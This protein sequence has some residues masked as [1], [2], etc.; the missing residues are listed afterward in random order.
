MTHRSSSRFNQLTRTA[1]KLLFKQG[2]ISLI[3]RL[4]LWLRGERRYFR[5]DNLA[6]H[7][8]QQA[9]LLYRELPPS[10]EQETFHGLTTLRGW[11]LARAGLERIEVYVDG[12]LAGQAKYGEVRPDIAATHPY[13]A[14]AD[15]AG[16]SFKWDTTSVSDGQHQ[17][18]FQAISSTGK[19]QTLTQEVIVDNSHPQKTEY[20][21]WIETYE[22]HDI[23]EA[24][25]KAKQLTVTP[26]F[27][28]IMP[29][30]N[31]DDSLLQQAIGSI[32]AQSYSNWEL[33]M[34]DDGSTTDQTWPRL[35]QAQ[36]VDDRI[37]VSRLET[38][39]GISAASNLALSQATGDFV[40]LMDQDDEL[41]P[42]ALY[43][44]AKW[45]NKFP[46]ADLLYSDEDK[47]DLDDRRYDPFFKPD[48][49]PDLFLSMNYLNH[50]TVIRTD[51]IRATGGFREGLEGSQDYD[52]YLRLTERTEQIYHIP[53]VL[54]H[55]RATPS[56]AAAD[57]RAKNFAQTAAQ[58]AL[59]EHLQRQQLQA[60]VQPVHAPGRWR[61]QYSVAAPP[62][63]AIIIPCYTNLK[64]LR[65]LT[66]HLIVKTTYRPIEFIIIDNSDGDEVAKVYQSI[67]QKHPETKYLNWQNHSFNFSKMNNAAV[68]LTDAPLLLFLNDDVE[69][70]N[71]DWLEAM[72]EH[73]QRPEVGVVGAKLV[74]P[75]QTIQHAG[76]VMGIYNNAGHAFKMMPADEK[77]PGYFDL[78]HIVRNCSAVTGACL[79]TERET[80]WQVGGFDEIHLAAAFQDVDYCL[81]V[82]QAG[83]RTIY[84]PHAR[85]YHYESK[86]KVK[87][88]REIM[89]HPYEVW[90]MQQVWGKVMTHDPYYNPNL[91][92]AAE[93]YSLRPTVPQHGW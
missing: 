38:N 71:N 73:I 1:G 19:K 87:T 42:H 68:E 77:R 23:E 64:G 52:L 57:S 34:A 26:K 76:V 4:Y 40:V 11:A 66:D 14:G 36:Q 37:K 18:R 62:P 55:W 7:Y 32:Q 78:P 41:P 61:I 82:G 2:P 90:Y 25:I 92:R 54:Y 30:Y 85:L 56:S 16:F 10:G 31:P 69:P 33:C 47:M 79:L 35:K 24:R 20:E 44:V 27:S 15:R 70:I 46:E 21:A 74:Y 8:E 59:E 83:Y 6:R 53:K 91:T 13:A 75:D 9:I 50:L 12:R 29:V 39:Q 72:V 17:L 65:T 5:P 43:F 63:I 67:A 81:K 86:T 45:L 51:L 22:S 80:F 88:N 93:D 89:P 49:S 48:W 60:T 58:Q 28:I 84:T 3:K